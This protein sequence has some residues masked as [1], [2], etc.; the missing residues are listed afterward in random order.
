MPELL[1]EAVQ[2]VLETMFFTEPLGMA[3]APDAGLTASVAFH[4]Q[5]SGELAVSISEGAVR[6]LAASFLGEDENDITDAQI[7]QVVCEIANMLCGSVVSRFESDTAFALAPPEL[8]PADWPWPRS[9]QTFALENGTLSVALH[10]A[11]QA[12]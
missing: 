12:P 2:T 1:T 9:S 11:G 3:P 7:E 8:L 5:P 4:G 10:V 6:P